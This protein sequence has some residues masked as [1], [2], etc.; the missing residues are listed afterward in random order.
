[1]RSWRLSIHLSL[2]NVPI[3]HTCV[4]HIHKLFTI[5]GSLFR[6]IL[7]E[8]TFLSILPDI[9]FFLF[10]GIQEVHD[11][12][13]VQLEIRASYETLCIFHSVD[14]SKELSERLLHKTIVFANH[15]VSLSR[16]S[17]SINKYTWVV[18]IKDII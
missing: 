10:F 9:E 11:L 3:F 2:A 15:C 12:L 14:S 18:P 5:E 17:L 13:I 16:P 7:D 4:E 1:M 6:K 8:D